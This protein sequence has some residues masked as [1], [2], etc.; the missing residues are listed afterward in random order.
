MIIR[1]GTGSFSLQ[2]S[3]NI[4]PEHTHRLNVPSQNVRRL[5]KHRQSQ[6]VCNQEDW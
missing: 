1:D 2:N 6:L 3:A 5:S 4:A